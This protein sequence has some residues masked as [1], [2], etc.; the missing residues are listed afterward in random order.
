MTTGL[1]G[2]PRH[3]RIGL[4]SHSA[5][6][7]CDDGNDV[8]CTVCCGICGDGHGMPRSQRH[9]APAVSPLSAL[10]WLMQPPQNRHQRWA[11]PSVKRARR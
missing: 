5:W 2:V 1:V 8:G 11:Q 3:G 9:R 6:H 4:C 7:R 10:P